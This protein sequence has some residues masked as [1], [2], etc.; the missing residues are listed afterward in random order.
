M[1]EANAG[2][3]IDLNLLRLLQALVD[4]GSVTR[5]GEAIGLS[6]PAA[7][8]AIAR[9][10]M[11]LRDP[12]IVRTGRGWVLTALAEQLARL[13]DDLFRRGE[14]DDS[15]RACSCCARVHGV[16]PMPEPWPAISLIAHQIDPMAMAMAPTHL[17]I[18]VIMRPAV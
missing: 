9:L 14:R 5:A 12:L 4:T 10:R 6:Q 17:T 1:H 13:L 11:C 3:T 15:G 2:R 18:R 7:S 8:R 16:G